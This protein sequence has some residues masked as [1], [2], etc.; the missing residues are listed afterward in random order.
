MPLAGWGFLHPRILADPVTL[1]VGADILAF[2]VILGILE[3]L[4]VW[5][6]LGVVGVGAEPALQVCF[7]HRFRP[8]ELVPQAGQEFMHPWILGGPSYSWCWGQI[9]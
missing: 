6:P 7:G 3:H 5:F 8:K 4:G 2:P 9:L 1:G